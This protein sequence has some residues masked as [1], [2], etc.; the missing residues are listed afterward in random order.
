MVK[1][2]MTCPECNGLGLIGRG[3][4]EK[5]CWVCD[6]DGVLWL[7]VEDEEELENEDIV[8]ERVNEIY[9]KKLHSA[10]CME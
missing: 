3:E 7:Y 9:W 10:S 8:T 4:D 5:I 1:E 2:R 6:G